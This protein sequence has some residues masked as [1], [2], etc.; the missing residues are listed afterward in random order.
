VAAAWAA[1]TASAALAEGPV[2][3]WAPCS[4]EGGAGLPAGGLASPSSVSPGRAGAI[5]ATGPGLQGRLGDGGAAERIRST[6]AFFAERGSRWGW[7]RG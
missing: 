5:P 2:A 3:S 6:E 7:R 1:A 4:E